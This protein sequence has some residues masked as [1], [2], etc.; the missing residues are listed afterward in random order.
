M[1]PVPG[2]ECMC[3][4]RPLPR[5]WERVGQEEGFFCSRSTQRFVM[6]PLP[7]VQV[8]RWPGGPGTGR[9]FALPWPPLCSAQRPAVKIKKKNFFFK[10][11]TFSC[12]RKPIFRNKHVISEK[13]QGVRKNN[14]PILLRSLRVSF[15][16]IRQSLLE[17]CAF[18]NPHRRLHSL[19]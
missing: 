5:G 9:Q 4:L 3:L 6:A 13:S 15:C 12:G 17:G 18:F 11:Y 2:S 19:I 10:G 8:A 14:M 1:T 7:L 16:V